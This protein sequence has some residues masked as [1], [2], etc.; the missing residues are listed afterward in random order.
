MGWALYRVEKSRCSIRTFYAST[1]Q[2]ATA[3][4][5]YWGGDIKP[6]QS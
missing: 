2:T 1:L 6:L 3:F 4:Q 5:R